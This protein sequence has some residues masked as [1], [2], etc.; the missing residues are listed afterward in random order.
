MRY[1]GVKPRFTTYNK[2]IDLLKGSYSELQAKFSQSILVHEKAS[3]GML[4]LLLLYKQ[5]ILFLDGVQIACLLQHTVF[6]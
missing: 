1:T 2:V 3:V 6:L 4:H 5:G